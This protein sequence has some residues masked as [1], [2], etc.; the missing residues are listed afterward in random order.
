MFTVHDLIAVINW[1][2]RSRR[3]GCNRRADSLSPPLCPGQ[4]SGADP[5]RRGGPRK[6]W[7]PGHKH[8]NKE[9]I[10]LTRFLRLSILKYLCCES[11]QYL[12]SSETPN[13][14][15]SV[16]LKQETWTIY[17]CQLRLPVTDA[18]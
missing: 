16:C 13:L 1:T 17:F 18:N 14:K 9:L 12:N 3:L 15:C 7:A 8:G 11:L 6:G 10:T 4:S 2:C 5:Q